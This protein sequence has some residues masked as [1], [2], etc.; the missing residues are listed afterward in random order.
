MRIVDYGVV[1]Q[2]GAW[3]IVGRNLR[4]GTF[5]KRCGAVRAARRLA[6]NSGGL[7]VRLHLQD[8]SG[9]LRTA[10]WVRPSR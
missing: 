9:E 8:E 5:R 10:E 3:I 6:D 4:Y 2:A 7:S 1:R